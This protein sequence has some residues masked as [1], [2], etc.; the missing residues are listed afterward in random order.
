MSLV[1]NVKDGDWV[2]VRQAIAK[3]SSQKLGIGSTPAFGSL[4]LTSPLTVPSGGLGVATLTTAY[5]LLAAGTTATGN[6]QTLAAGLTTQILVG[7]GTSALPAW[8]TNVP[9]AVTIGSA[10][11]YRVGG[12]DVSVAD[13][14][15]GISTLTD[16]GILLGSGTSAI[17]PLGEATNGQL[18]IGSTGFDP[19]LATISEG[20]GIDIANAAGSITIAG[21]DASTTNKGIA[22]FNSTYFSVASGVVSLISGGGLSHNDLSGLQ[23]GTTAKY[24]HLTDTEYGYVSGAN[25]QS[26]LTTGSPTFAG[27]SLIAATNSVGLFQWAST[28]GKGEFA[29]QENTTWMGFVG[30][31]G[32]AYADAT[33]RNAFIFTSGVNDLGTIIFKTRTSSSYQARMTIT[34]AGIINISNLTAS[35]LVATDASKNL[36][37]QSVGNLTAGSTKISIGGT[38][39]GA[40]VGGGATVDVSEA[41]LTHNNVGS[42]QGGTAGEYYHLTSAQTTALHAGVTLATSADVLLGLTGQVLSLDTQ[43]ATYVLAGPVSG[44]AA[45]PTFRALASTDIPALAYEASGAVGTHAALTTG[46]HGLLITAGQTLT[47]TTGGTLGTAAYTASSAY[48]VPLTFSTG[49]NRATNTITCTITQ[50]TDALARAALSSSATG[51]T[52]TSSTGAFSLTT[53]YVIPTTTQET[54]WNSAYSASHARQHAITATADHTS[55]ATAAYLLKADTNGLPVTA[56]NTDAAVAAAVTASHAAVTLGTSNGLSLV[57]QEL[58]L[59]VTATPTFVR[60]TCPTIVGGTATTSSLTLKTTT[61]A[62]TTGA[63]VHICVGNNGATEGLTI[64]NNGFVGINQKTPLY[65]VHIKEPWAWCQGFAMEKGDIGNPSLFLGTGNQW[66]GL[67]LSGGATIVGDPDVANW[68]YPVATEATFYRQR[69]GFHVWYGNVSLTTTTLYTPTIR[70]LLSADGKL[71]VGI[72]P[73]ETIHSVAKVRA[74][75]AFNLNGT[76]GVTQAASAGKISVPE[77]IAGGIV[78]TQSQ[79]TYAADGTYALPTSITISHGIITS[80]S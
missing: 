65:S 33:C 25:A 38:G 74:D 63:D 21:E 64:L 80:I 75:T 68:A 60:L 57:G 16:H 19:V 7:G 14:G 5:G 37:S 23:G 6:V 39:T 11:I 28:S 30:C 27:L 53:N 49:L 22:S 10:Y 56:T 73:V 44:V 69:T 62:G 70:M 8:G 50:Y 71:G 55:T 45:A 35:Q 42:L 72:T 29:F 34:N 18:P 54:N 67:W 36:V 66:N 26:V 2:S 77:S 61:G 78:T 46:I 15:T 3:L 40:L 41:N 32:S 17:T 13:G 31:Y 12:T 1:S 58:S 48:E 47:V 4:T 20:E 79:V 76:D 51:L 43:T 24:Y 9:T 59:P 52:Y